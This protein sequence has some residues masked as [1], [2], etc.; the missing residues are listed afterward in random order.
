M[1]E[2]LSVAQLH[3]VNVRVCSA[4]V[5]DW[6]FHH[7]VTFDRV[8]TAVCNN[9]GRLIGQVVGGEYKFVLD[10][11]FMTNVL[12]M[13]DLFN[14]PNFFCHIELLTLCLQFKIET[15]VMPV[16]GVII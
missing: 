1:E 6:V 13:F 12:T 10:R 5:A 7:H 8:G 15:P 4:Q 14:L 11:N 3:R 2:Q 16:T 9:V